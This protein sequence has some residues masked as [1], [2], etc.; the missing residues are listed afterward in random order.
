MVTQRL[1]TKRQRG[2]RTAASLAPTRNETLQRT[3][4]CPRVSG[5]LE[6]GTPAEGGPGTFFQPVKKR[7]QPCPACTH[8]REGVPVAQPRVH[9]TLA[10][11]AA[12]AGLQGWLQGGWASR[13][14][15]RS[16]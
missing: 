8:V 7:R 2:R 4:L 5:A 6:G 13:R 15:P 11:Q 12:C 10:C 9:T 3:W 1:A 16:P 14:L